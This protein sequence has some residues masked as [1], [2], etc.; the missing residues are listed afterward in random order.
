M[1]KSLW[2]NVLL[3]AHKILFLD[4]DDG[5]I[6]IDLYVDGNPAP[7]RH[8]ATDISFTTT[9]TITG[10]AFDTTVFKVGMP[11]F[12]EEKNGTGFPATDGVNDGVYTIATVSA[13]TITV[14]ADKTIG[15]TQTAA[16]AGTVTLKT[17]QL[18]YQKS[19]AEADGFRYRKL[20][21]HLNKIGYSFKIKYTI[22]GTGTKP[23]LL[24]HGLLWSPAQEDLLDKD[25]WA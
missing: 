5:T 22:E 8:T 16:E 14:T 11:L 10:T 19:M 24:G 13:T 18:P 1:T 25:D 17:V 6:T 4:N 23:K 9:D 2:D 20:I 7:E 15:T 21:S 3:Y 12:V